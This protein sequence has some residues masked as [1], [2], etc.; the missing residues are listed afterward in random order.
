MISIPLL[1]FFATNITRVMAKMKL[2]GNQIT[3]R[4][5]M[6]QEKPNFLIDVPTVFKQPLNKLRAKPAPLGISLLTKRRKRNKPEDI[7][8]SPDRGVAVKINRRRYGID[9]KAVNSRHLRLSN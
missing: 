9:R 2:E 1:T 3:L 4:K 5:L 6:N 7:S 8:D